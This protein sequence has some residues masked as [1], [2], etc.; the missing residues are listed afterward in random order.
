MFRVHP[1]RATC[2]THAT[3]D[4]LHQNVPAMQSNVTLSGKPS[5]RIGRASMIACACN[6]TR[7]QSRHQKEPGT[8]SDLKDSGLF[9]SAAGVLC[10]IPY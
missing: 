1:F 9:E 2:P 5:L 7:L 10:T 8:K 3:D 4:G 6:G